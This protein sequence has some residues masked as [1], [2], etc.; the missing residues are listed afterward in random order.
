MFTMKFIDGSA[1]PHGYLDR[2]SALISAA[3]EAEEKCGVDECERTATPD[4]DER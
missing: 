1:V 4:V 2:V 3:C